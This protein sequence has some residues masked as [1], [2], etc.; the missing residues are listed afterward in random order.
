MKKLLAILLALFVFLLVSCGTTPT[1]TTS[2]PVPTETSSDSSEI[3]LQNQLVYAIQNP[4]F[5]ETKS[6]VLFTS[7]YRDDFSAYYSKADGKGYHLCFDPLCEHNYGSCT[8]YSINLGFV[9][10]TH[11]YQDRIYYQISFWQD[12]ATGE[13]NPAILSCKFDGTDIRMEYKLKSNIFGT[14]TYDR[15]M[16][17]YENKSDGWMMLLRYDLETGE[18]R[19]LSAEQGYPKLAS[20][21]NFFYNDKMYF[22]TNV[23]FGEA[24][25]DLSD[26]QATSEQSETLYRICNGAQCYGSRSAS[27]GHK[28]D[29][30][31]TMKA[32]T[33]GIHIYDIET[34]EEIIV[35]PEVCGG[36]YGYVCHVDADYIYY[37]IEYD[38]NWKSNRYHGKI[39]RM[40]W[41][42]TDAKCIYDN[43]EMDINGNLYVTGDTMLICMTTY[44][45]NY[46]QC[47]DVYV[48]HIE[49][50]GMLTDVHELIIE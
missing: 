27:F 24:N 11:I 40:K 23:G 48:A 17:F 1:G 6:R 32:F 21:P 50:D 26:Y 44:G 15:Y 16:Y 33:D 35:P 37:C 28:I 20:L 18:M 2:I 29:Y 41:D 19:N 36:E 10:S 30:T 13:W 31:P 12:P 7:Y 45:N 5:Y 39:F 43:P 8:S 3:S 49:E 4:F 34:N 14:P 42:G 22:H 47:K 9:Y 25:L 46:A 38:P